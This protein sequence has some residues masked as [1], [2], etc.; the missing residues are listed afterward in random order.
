[1]SV[2]TA[3]IR[4]DVKRMRTEYFDNS[5]IDSAFVDSPSPSEGPDKILD[6]SLTSFTPD[7]FD[8]LFGENKLEK[9]NNARD[10]SN[11]NR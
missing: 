7:Y 6:A 4:F 1:M 11:S 10:R 8:C 5:E 9:I 2:H 3:E